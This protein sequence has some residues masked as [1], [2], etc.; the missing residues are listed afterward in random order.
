MGEQD[1]PADSISY[2]VPYSDSPVGGYAVGS[3]Q[4]YLGLPTVGQVG[5]ANTVRHAV[6]WSRAYNL[7]WNEWFRDQNLQDSVVV[8]LDDGPDAIAD[9]VLSKRGKRH[10]YFTS[11]LP[12]PQKGDAINMP[13]GDFAPVVGIAKISTT[14]VD[15]A[16]SGYDYNGAVSYSTSA[17]INNGTVNNDFVVEKQA[18]NNY[19]NIVADLSNATAA[20]INSMREAFQLQRLLERDARGGTRYAEHLRSHWG[21]ISPDQRLQR[22]EFL[23]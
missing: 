21:V 7:I 15:G 23:S 6:F 1:N 13:L 20:T 4:D 14:W 18:G 9:Y 22:P 11:A 5:G 19:P 3:L 8:D 10:D 12:W 2:I 17:Y 16:K